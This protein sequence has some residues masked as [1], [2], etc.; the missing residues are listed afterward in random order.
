M[1][2]VPARQVADGVTSLI[3]SHKP[4]LLVCPEA[5]LGLSRDPSRTV[6]VG[7]VERHNPSLDGQTSVECFYLL[8]CA[9]IERR[10]E[11]RPVCSTRPQNPWSECEVSL[12]PR[13][14]GFGTHATLLGHAFATR[15][16]RVT[17]ASVGERHFQ[18]S[19]R[20]VLNHCL[21]CVD[22]H[23]RRQGGSRVGGS[24]T[25]GTAL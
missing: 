17:V 15:A 18:L 4:R 2:L 25:R 13:H 3:S 11:R 23:V 22:G 16:T 8:P 21:F 24:G 9:R 14:S 10:F 1:E 6:A 20:A 5:A 12:R 7:L 19:I